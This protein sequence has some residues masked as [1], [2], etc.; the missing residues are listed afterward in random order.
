MA[1]QTPALRTGHVRAPRTERQPRNRRQRRHK[2][3]RVKPDHPT[4]ATAHKTCCLKDRLHLKAGLGQ[5]AHASISETCAR[6]ITLKIPARPDCFSK[7]EPWCFRVSSTN[8]PRT[9]K[10]RAGTAFKG[11]CQHAMKLTSLLYAQSEL[12]FTSQQEATTLQT[13]KGY[14]AAIEECMRSSELLLSK[15]KCRLPDAEQ[16]PD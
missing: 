3:R 9:G 11:H 2:Q 7:T 12:V 6:T 14:C 16:R 15:T 13:F 8:L 1:V 5:A 4:R 10:W